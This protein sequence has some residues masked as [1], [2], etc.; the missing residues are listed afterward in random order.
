MVQPVEQPLI[1]LGILYDDF[2][3]AID[4]Q[5][6]RGFSLFETCHVSLMIAEKIS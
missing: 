3:A 1:A 6:L 5:N 2:G 4:R